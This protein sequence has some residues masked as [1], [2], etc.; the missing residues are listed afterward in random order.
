MGGSAFIVA[1]LAVVVFVHSCAVFGFALFFLLAEVLVECGLFFFA[2][3]AVAV[4]VEL[5]HEFLALCGFFEHGLLEGTPLI[6]GHVAVAIEVVLCEE[7]FSQLHAHGELFEVGEQAVAVDI[8]LVH[9][10]DE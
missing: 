2:E 5:G 1:D 3:E 4:E 8:E 7:L 10:V 6:A 9:A